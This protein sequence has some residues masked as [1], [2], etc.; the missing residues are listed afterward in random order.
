MLDDC[1]I[2]GAGTVGLSLAI[3]FAQAGY[4]V[5]VLERAKT[6]PSNILPL[7]Q[8]TLALSYASFRILETLGVWQHLKETV[9]PIKQVEVS[10]QGQ[11]GACRI[12]HQELGVETLG[13]VVGLN[14]LETALLSCAKKLE[15][16]KILQPATL[17]ETKRTE[18]AWQLAIHHEASLKTMEA[19]LL[20]AAEGTESKLR[21]KEG[22][23]CRKYE[24]SHAAIMLNV[25]FKARLPF[26]AIERFLKKGALAFLPWQEDLATF[27]FTIPKTEAADYMAL[28]EEEFINVCQKALGFSYGKIVSLGKRIVVP[29]SMLLAD[30]QIAN[31]FLLMGNAAH[32]LHPIAAQ[33]LNLSLRDIW[34]LRSQ[35]LIAREHCDLGNRAFLESYQQARESDQKRIIFATDKIARFM[36]GGPLPMWLRAKG[37]FLFDCMIPLKNQF[38]RYSLGLI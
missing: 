8:R 28:S 12:Q 6:Q 21:E 7:N 34:Q 18:S 11:F 14:N 4:T 31:R 32:T 37:M 15:K 26:A 1:V 20:V 24:Y 16:I 10:V 27:V 38:S 22:I 33:G 23:S 25:Q 36:S 2:V 35:L 9:V 19:K 17:V 30:R 13:Y 5:T 3:A 29:L